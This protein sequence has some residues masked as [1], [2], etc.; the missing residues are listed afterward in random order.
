MVC[1]LAKNS[2]LE[3]VMK[4]EKFIGDDGWTMLGV[5]GIIILTVAFIIGF[6]WTT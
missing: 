6:V 4:T 3:K 2:R 1:R 5:L